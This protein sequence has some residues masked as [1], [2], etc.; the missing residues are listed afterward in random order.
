MATTPVYETVVTSPPIRREEGS[1]DPLQHVRDAQPTS[2]P[3]VV[4]NN[5]D[6]CFDDDDDDY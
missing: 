2:K 3:P 4:K 1:P 6:S 5:F